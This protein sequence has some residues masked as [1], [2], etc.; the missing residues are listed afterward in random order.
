MINKIDDQLHWIKFSISYLI[1]NSSILFYSYFKYDSS[2]YQQL[3]I[4]SKEFLRHSMYILNVG[5]WL[6]DRS[7]PKRLAVEL[8]GKPQL[9]Y[10][11]LR[12]WMLR[13]RQKLQ[14]WWCWWQ[15]LSAWQG[16]SH[17]RVRGEWRRLVQ[18]NHSTFALCSCSCRGIQSSWFHWKFVM[19]I[20]PCSEM[21]LWKH[22]YGLVDISCKCS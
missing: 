4:L 2:H 8:Q 13:C 17:T 16:T 14:M 20:C 22:E 9:R 11:Y 1:L 19:I 7:S 10:V 18:L 5:L 15:S 21:H 3:L 6:Y 12:P